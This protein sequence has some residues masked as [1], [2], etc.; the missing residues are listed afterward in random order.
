[1][2]WGFYRECIGKWEPKGRHREF[3]YLKHFILS[4]GVYVSDVFHAIW[5]KDSYTVSECADIFQII[6]VIGF[7]IKE[8][9]NLLQQ[10]APGADFGTL[11]G[12]YGSIVGSVVA[13]LVTGTVVSEYRSF[14]IKKEIINIV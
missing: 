14:D 3:R 7:F 11:Y 8:F 4:T 12:F 1:M 13:G 10:G 2:F 6:V 5:I 9:Q